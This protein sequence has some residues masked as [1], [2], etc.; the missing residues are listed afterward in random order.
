TSNPSLFG[1]V[2]VPG[3][4]RPAGAADVSGQSPLEFRLEFDP[5]RDA[6]L[7]FPLLVTASYGAGNLSDQAV[8]DLAREIS[9]AND[10]L[11]ELYAATHDYYARFF[12]NKMTIDTP[13][14]AVNDA[15]RWA[16]LAI[17]Q[18][19]LKLGGEAGLA[20]GWAA[21]GTSARPGFGWFFGRD[22]LWS[23]FAIDN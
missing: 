22:A 17:D 6:N 8:N 12:D 1:I 21:S 18:T 5:H 3:A 19:R 9:E 14:R 16:E 10:K 23:L 13:D 2:A 20:A 15:F 7:L 4:D 11:P